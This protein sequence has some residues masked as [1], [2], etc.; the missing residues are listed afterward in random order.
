VD[1]DA[2]ASPD[3]RLGLLYSVSLACICLALREAGWTFIARPDHGSFFFRGEE[4]ASATYLVD[5]VAYGRASQEA[6]SELCVRTGI[7]GMRMSGGMSPAG[8]GNRWTPVL[9]TYVPATAAEPGL[10]YEGGNG[11]DINT[12]IIIR[13]TRFEKQVVAA[14]LSR[15]RDWYGVRGTDWEL[16]G[17]TRQVHKGR[18]IDV[19]ELVLKNGRKRFLYFDVTECQPLPKSSPADS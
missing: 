13:G 14:Q 11:A 6:W 9:R 18:Q 15:L 3:D 5:M 17:Q 8:P 4:H 2:P 16:V 1:G 19:Y 12:P 7:S 10:R